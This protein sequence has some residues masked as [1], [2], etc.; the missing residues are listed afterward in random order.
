M[1]KEDIVNTY[2]SVDDRIL[3][4]ID[5]MYDDIYLMMDIAVDSIEDER[6]PAQGTGD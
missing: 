6:Q 4:T 5:E 2:G 1:N 3:M